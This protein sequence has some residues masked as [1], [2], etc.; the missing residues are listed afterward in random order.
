MGCAGR[1]ASPTI[2]TRTPDG[3]SGTQTGPHVGRATPTHPSLRFDPPEPGL[4]RHRRRMPIGGIRS[5]RDK[6]GQRSRPPAAA[7]GPAAAPYIA[8]G[9]RQLHVVAGPATRGRDGTR[10]VHVGLWG[11]GHCSLTQV[12]RD[13][14]SN[15]T[16]VV[17]PS[18]TAVDVYAY[19]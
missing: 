6:A 16:V 13:S 8:L 18:L 9:R 4:T 15:A 3:G 17:M 19:V 11:R 7:F 14:H 5:R 12:R 1:V 10:E 2:P